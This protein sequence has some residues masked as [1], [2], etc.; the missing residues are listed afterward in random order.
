MS[1][2]VGWPTDVILASA[3][4]ARRGLLESLG[5]VVTTLPTDVDETR[6]P[7]ES[8]RDY[9]LR[10]ALS[11]AQRAREHAPDG[12]LIVTADTAVELEDELLGKPT[13]T[14]EAVA[15][16]V[17]LSGRT[18]RVITSVAVTTPNQTVTTVASSAVRFYDLPD[19]LLNWYASTGEGLGAAGGY[20]VQGIGA[21][22]IAEVFGSITNIIG[23]PIVELHE[24]MERAHRS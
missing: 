8:A 7:R 6:R 13:D 24:L 18:H 17:A 15:T 5:L 19:A 10:L 16:L 2:P 4:P 9:V 20:R 22:L 14:A 21:F 12:Q 11:K 23:L 3:S 1:V